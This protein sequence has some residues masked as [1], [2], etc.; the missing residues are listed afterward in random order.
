MNKQIRGIYKEA[1]KGYK[2]ISKTYKIL[3]KSYDLKIPI[4]SAGQWILDNMYIIEEA[5]DDIKSSLKTIR[6]LKLP[7]VKL[8]DGT[9]HT[10]IFY[11]AYELV[12]NNTGYIDKNIILNTLKEYQKLSY[13]SSD[14]LDLFIL[15]LKISIIKFIA[16]I[17]LN[18]TNSQQ[19]KMEVEKIL[20][21]EYSSNELVKQLYDEFSSFKKFKETVLDTTKIK[22]TNTAFVEY[23][24]YRLKEMGQKGD[25]Y[26]NLLN[27][28]AGKIGFTIDEAIIKEHS[29]IAKTTDYIGRAILSFKNLNGINFREIFEKVNKIDETL[30]ND[31][32]N[33]F[34][35]CDYKTKTRYRKYIIKLSKKYNLSEVYVAQKAVECSKKYKK[36]V[37]F[38]LIGNNKYLLKKQIGKSY[39]IDLLY[40]KLIKPSLPIMYILFNLLISLIGIIVTKNIITSRYT[41]NNISMKYI[42][43][44][45]VYILYME[46]SDKLIGYILRKLVKP[47]ILP[48]FD[49][50]KTIDKKYPT[51][52]VMPTIISSIEKLDAMINKMEVTYL[53]NRSENMYYMLLGDCMSSDKEVIDIDEKI[54]K[55]ATK[56]L[57]ELNNKYP[58]NHKLFNFM[59]RKRVYSKSE[60]CYMG[61]ERKRGALTHFNK[62]ILGKLTDKEKEKYM[63]LIYDDIIDAKYAITIDEDSQLSLNTAKDLVAIISHPLNKPVLSKD[64]RRVIDGYGLIQPSVGLDIQIANKS[65]FSKIFG[66]F[67]G[68]DIYTNAVANTYQDVFGEAIFCGKGIYDISLFEEIV[69]PIIPENLVLS[70]DLLEGSILR[71]GLASDIE[72]QDGFPSNYVAYMKRNHRWY[73]GD[74]QIIRWLLSPKSYL[75]I[76]SK[77][78]IFD[79]IRRPLVYVFSLLLILLVGLLEPKLFV[80]ATLMVF[81][82]VNAGDIL[83]L[84]N[85]VI[86]GKF[87]H[88]K[89]LQYIP[90]ING[91]SA[92]LLTMCFNFVTIPY[93]AYTALN[94]FFTSL[95]R[96]LISK[97]KLLEWTTGEVLDKISK[98][99]FSYYLYNMFPNIITSLILFAFAIFGFAPNIFT[100]NMYIYIGLFFLV[101]PIFA[102]LLGKDHIIKKNK[103]ISK[104]KNE[105]I[106]EIAKRTWNFFDNMMSEVNNFLPTDNYQ[107]TRRYKIANRT[108]STNIG[109]A[110]LSVI[111]AF[112]LGF[113]TKEDAIQK[114]YNT[115]LT[116]EKL[117][118]WNGH[119]Y[120]WYNIKTLQP[121]RPR[122]I[123]T[124]D[125]GNFV[126]CLYVLKQFLLEF[127]GSTTFTKEISFEDSRVDYMLKL[128]DKL[129]NDTNFKVLYNTDRNLFS[130]GYDIEGGK[131]VDSYY[132]MLM[133]ESRTTSLI[134]ISNMQVTSKHW[135]ALSRNLVKLDGYSGLKSWSGT[136]FEYFM[137]YIFNKSYEHTLIDQSLF[138]AKYSQIKY[139]KQNNVAWGVSECG[140]AV[141]DDMLNYQYKAFGIPWLGLKRGLNN[142]LIISPYSSL[143]MIEYDPEKVY[144]NI[145]QLKKLGMYSTYGF[146]E[147]IDY[148]KSH[149]SQNESS[150]IIKSYLAHHQGMILS[151]INNYLNNGI[152]KE[153]FHKNPNIKA[154]E[155]LLKERERY[156][157]IIKKGVRDKENVFK[158]KDLQK[159]T[160]YI[161]CTY[162]DKE[163]IK[164]NDESNKLSVGFLK[165]A[166]LTAIVTNSGATYLKYK[167]K[168]LNRQS[169]LDLSNTGNYIY[170][171]DKTTGKCFSATNTNIHSPFNRDTLKCNWINSLNQIECYIEGKEIEATTTITLSQDYN[172]QIQKVSLYNNSNEGREIVI[173]TF[174]EPAMTDFMTNVVHPS[175]NNLL[176]ETS[177][178]KDLDAIIATRRK[179]SPSDESIY[180]YSKL[181]GID[182]E[183]QVET[184]KL[185]LTKEDENAY[186]SDIS[187]YPLW[188][189][190]SYRASII[191]DPYERQD[192]YYILGVADSKYNI[193]NAIV[194]L[195]KESLEQQFRNSAQIN[196]VTA[197]YLKL[198]PQKTEIYNNI[199]KDA[200][201]TIKVK[202]DD[203]YWNTD[204]KQS[205]LWKYSISGDFPI[206]L[207]YI[208]KIE[209]AIII[210]EIIKFMDYVKNRKINIDIV[211][212]INEEQKEFGPLY[213]YVKKAL[214]RAV[215]MDYTDGKI[216]LLNIKYLEN[217]EITLLTYLAKKYINNVNEFTMKTVENKTNLNLDE[218]KEEE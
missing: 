28:E 182:L 196:S 97:K 189:V 43:Y 104:A 115:S 123:S 71:T 184:E 58:N 83:S 158:Q 112:D 186:S 204:L 49:F 34:S 1:T 61:W 79:N 172:A 4:H 90:I 5:Y 72:M 206:I 160:T 96:M 95:Y 111:D 100:L 135:F 131:L 168:I 92:E 165:G 14:E 171:T 21:A 27:D 120:N 200:L 150:E 64:R 44:I 137:P 175:F 18:I 57:E 169:Y 213:T 65:I 75:N 154:T 119:L 147:S 146:Y 141:K 167:D 149:L 153:R 193:S 155:I 38:F 128:I 52:I 60:G 208:D 107:E 116:I 62:L 110:L 130:I 216:F 194:N 89:D 39:F 173:N 9:K 162:A 134:A 209:D 108:S 45:L 180:L 103:N 46:I 139:A 105:E 56:K 84:F 73:R 197:R 24:A 22:N 217:N 80:T 15:L 63:Y 198:E 3:E 23:M 152:I 211:V 77:W 101:A 53:S 157:T 129:I 109:F 10:A 19:K 93:I 178:D 174:L 187:K 36:H 166:N 207:V 170:I 66:G 179:K 114:L 17:C 124:V 177:Y 37:G 25:N 55:Y 26:Y 33:E 199:L 88:S 74:M 140:Y 202:E 91:I 125:S 12:E 195:D 190:L 191:L 192:F 99:S 142:Y 161:N 32:T 163:Y 127:K 82:I 86:Y 7:V 185:K 144:K 6:N 132:D 47:K 138:F 102:Y 133:S 54:V 41:F 176:I 31:Y 16:R 98:S 151:S 11:I 203:K 50:A 81:V 106:K 148:T 136:A 181:V 212:L 8:H 30:R 94:A 210:N 69:A 156:K 70:H 201:F 188:P 2:I 183:K 76:L 59:Y 214:D 85:M 20:S 205:L 42:F 145:V 40:Y 13:L 218:T 122:F 215:Y 121:L 164:P 35:K 68:L 118:K 143:L 159:Y 48:R 78:K 87:R 67:G 126:A 29:E 117:E 51:Y 113:I